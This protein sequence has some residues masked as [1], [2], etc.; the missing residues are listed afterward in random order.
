VTA[1]LVLCVGNTFRH[2]DGAGPTVALHL[3]ALAPEVD[4][5]E[6]D[7]EPARL[8]EAWDGAGLAVLVD[9]SSSGAPPGTVH[10][11]ELDPAVDDLVADTRT[12]STHA[13]SLGDALGLG[14][15]LGRLPARL[16]VYAI[17]GGDFSE[18]IGV[19]DAVA[20]A[21]LE[22]ARTLAR[23]L[24]DESADEAVTRPH[25]PSGEVVQ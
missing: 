15:A 20:R 4:V 2:D 17:E 25:P 10:R 5:V 7:G 23:E 6:L 21:S 9:A 1:P 22:V 12:A 13:Y 24:A 16:V 18:G 3:R 14:R 19:S 8:V 11:R